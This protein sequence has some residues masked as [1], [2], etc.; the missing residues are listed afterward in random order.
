MN[1]IKNTKDFIKWA[2]TY[3]YPLEWIVKGP[4]LYINNYELLNKEDSFVLYPSIKQELERGE[5]INKDILKDLIYTVKLFSDTYFTSKEN[6][7]IIYDDKTESILLK[8]QKIRN[9]YIINQ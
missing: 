5:K 9:N 2:N 1:S 3:A 4:Y 6:R 8:I 7:S